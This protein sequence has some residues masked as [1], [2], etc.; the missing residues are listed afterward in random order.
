MCSLLAVLTISVNKTSIP[1]SYLQRRLKILD[2][3]EAYL[4]IEFS[5]VQLKS[6]F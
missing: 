4:I 3:D 2:T 1:E 6:L 5:E